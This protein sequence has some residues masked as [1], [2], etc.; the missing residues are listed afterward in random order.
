M[1][2]GVCCRDVFAV[3]PRALSDHYVGGLG[4][5]DRQGPVIGHLVLAPSGYAKINL[6]TLT[7]IQIVR[8]FEDGIRSSNGLKKGRP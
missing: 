5:W 7:S 4:N 6:S 1:S 2:A 8:V 3:K